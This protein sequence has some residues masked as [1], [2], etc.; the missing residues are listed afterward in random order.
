VSEIEVVMRVKL[1]EAKCDEYVRK[2]Y[3]GPPDDPVPGEPEPGK[4][5]VAE[6]VE[7]AQAHLDANESPDLI[8]LDGDRGHV[9]SA[10][11]EVVG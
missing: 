11:I 2:L 6:W 7:E 3:D 1:D 8:W 4:R 10:K 9:L 5:M